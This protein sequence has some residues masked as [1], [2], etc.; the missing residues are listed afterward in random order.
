MGFMQ[1]NEI[2][3]FKKIQQGKIFLLQWIKAIIF[4]I[5]NACMYDL[6]AGCAM[7][8]GRSMAKIVYG[9]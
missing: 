5:I 8:I 1:T 7:K 9:Q 3:N 4:I 6:N 2:L